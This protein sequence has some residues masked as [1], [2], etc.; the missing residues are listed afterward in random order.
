M[1]ILKVFKDGFLTKQDLVEKGDFALSDLTSG[2]LLNA[3][4]ED[5][6]FQKVIDYPALIQSV[7]RIQMPAPSYEISKIG[8]GSRAF[9]VATSGVALASNKRSQPTTDKLTLT[10]KKIMAQFNMTYEV[11]EDN[12]EKGTLEDTLLSLFSKRLALDMEELALL[13]DPALAGT[14]DDLAAF[15]GYLKR[16]TSHTVNASTLGISA[17]T[18]NNAIIALPQ[19]YR[20]D[21]SAFRFYVTP[22]AKQT[23]KNEVAGRQTALG[24][25]TLTG[26]ADVMVHGVPLIGVPLMP[27][28]TG[29]FTDPQNLIMGIQ[30]AVTMEADRDIEAQIIK[31]VFS[32]RVDFQIEEEDMCV[33]L[34]NLGA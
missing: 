13:G 29:I 24:D 33:K 4:Q 31:F 17:D 9:H 8:F 27:S 28:G 2:G 15:T 1:K 11:F 20:R 22:N 10:S 23:W 18:F 3:T 5:K 34:T 19:K 12:I 21:M 14:D 32:A 25:S 30:R 7:R 26:K 6:F 16:L